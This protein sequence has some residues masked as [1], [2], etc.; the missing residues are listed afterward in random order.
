MD[1]RTNEIGN[2]CLQNDLAGYGL[3]ILTIICIPLWILLVVA[4]V[5]GNTKL[6]QAKQR[7]T[8]VTTADVYDVNKCEVLYSRGIYAEIGVRTKYTVTYYFIDDSN[9]MVTF[10]IDYNTNP[11]YPTSLDIKYNPDDSNEYF[12]SS[13]TNPMNYSYSNRS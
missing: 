6:Y 2:K 1:V 10:A 13:E 8:G 7:C 4:A 11:D 12:W 9:E 5:Y 3:K